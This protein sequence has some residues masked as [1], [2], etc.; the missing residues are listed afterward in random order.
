MTARRALLIFV[1]PF[2]LIGATVIETWRVL[3]QVPMFVR[4]GWRVEL[5]EAKRIWQSRAKS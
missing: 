3:R 4:A 1:L 2:A 5:S